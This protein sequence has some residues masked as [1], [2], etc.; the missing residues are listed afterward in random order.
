MSRD[1][2]RRFLFYFHWS[3][4]SENV[5]NNINIILLSFFYIKLQVCVQTRWCELNCILICLSEYTWRLVLAI[6]GYPQNLVARQHFLDKIRLNSRPRLS[7]NGW[8]IVFLMIR[9][10]RRNET[11][12]FTIVSY[13]CVWRCL[14][15]FITGSFVEKESNTKLGIDLLRNGLES[16]LCLLV[17]K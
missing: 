10:V 4:R 14:N 2:V 15:C 12:S 13:A 1:F 6:R 7:L 9:V 8:L 11:T 16:Q 5:G 3:R 17:G